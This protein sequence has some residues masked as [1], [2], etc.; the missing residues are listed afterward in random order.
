MRYALANFIVKGVSTTIP[1]HQALLSHP[2]YIHSRVNTRW[3]EDRFMPSY[4]FE[5]VTA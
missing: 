2:D 3:T 1:F 4:T 5:G